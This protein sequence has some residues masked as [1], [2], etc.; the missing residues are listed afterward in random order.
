MLKLFSQLGY[1]FFK[2]TGE[3]PDSLSRLFNEIHLSGVGGVLSKKDKLL[4]VI[5]WLRSYLSY[6]FLASL[7]NISVSTVKELIKLT[8][9]I[10]DEH[11]NDY[12]QWPVTAEWSS[13]C[14][15]WPKIPVAVYAIDGTSHKIY[16]PVNNQQQYYLSHRAYHCIHTQIIV[17]NNG[18]I[19]HIETGFLGHKNDAQQ[20]DL[21]T[22][23]GQDLPFLENCVLLADKIYPNRHPLMTPYTSAQIRRMDNRRQA[24]RFN[25]FVA[26]YRI[27]V[28]QAVA[29]IKAYKSI[30]SVWR[31]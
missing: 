5:L 19:R 28:E 1:D 6:H 30:S 13:Y 15:N 21:M 27:A 25:R 9:P 4:L 20:F 3:T 22:R 26:H 29:E 12:L 8:V 16:R 17:D 31:H 23:I 14:G 10:L 18:C 24:R 7:F 2:V 11:L